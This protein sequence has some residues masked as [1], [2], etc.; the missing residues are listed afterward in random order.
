L[1]ELAALDDADFRTMFSGSPIKRIGRDRFVRNV[2]IAIGNSGDPSLRPVATRLTADGNEVVA[3]A[4]AW[5]C[6][7]L[8]S[9]AKA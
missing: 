5:A 8:N 4:A 7:R 9:G 1:A 3:E 2:L 6:E